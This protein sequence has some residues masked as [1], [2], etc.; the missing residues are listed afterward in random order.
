MTLTLALT[1]VTAHFIGDFL[2]QSDYMALN[3][4]KSTAVLV[5]HVWTYTL[6]LAVAVAVFDPTNPPW[7]FLMVNWLAHFFQDAITSRVNTRLWFLELGNACTAC[8]EQVWR[9]KNPNTRHWF[10]VSI[11][12]DQLL[13]YVTLF[14]T[15]AWWL[16]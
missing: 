14:V 5:W 7:V 9:M 12:F 3:K 11:G 6:T 15:A 4:S 2:L 13:H 1:L 16:Q 8:D 10:F